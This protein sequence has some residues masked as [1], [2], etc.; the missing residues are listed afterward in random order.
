MTKTN[1][2]AKKTTAKTEAKASTAK[3]STPAPAAKKEGL[4][5]P[6]V[7]I[8]KAL[9]KAGKPLPRKTIAE[10]APVD[11]AACVEYLGSHDDSI[12]KAN[13][14]KHFPSLVTLGLVKC[15]IQDVDGRDVVVYSVTAKGRD[16]AKKAAE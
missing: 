9:A 13:D 5:A 8:L 12:R 2:N 10:K 15:E 14:V 4:R 16:A 6:Q 7:R 11:Q 3:K 1:D